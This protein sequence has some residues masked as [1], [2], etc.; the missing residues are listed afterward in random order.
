MAQLWYWLAAKP[1]ASIVGDA[2]ASV[3]YWRISVRIWPALQNA[4]VPA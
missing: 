2:A 4:V 3:G 1:L